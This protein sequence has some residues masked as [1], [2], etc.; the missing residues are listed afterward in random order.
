MALFEDKCK[1][2]VPRLMKDLNITREQAC[3]IFGNLGTETGGFKHLQ[4]LNPTVAGSRGGYGWMQ[5]TGPRRKAYEAWAK[6]NGLNIADDETNYK[7]LVYETLNVENK[8]LVQLRKTTT[9]EAAAETFCLLNLRPGVTHMASRKA[10]AARA[11]EATKALPGAGT[12]IIATTTAAT[13]ATIAFWQHPHFWPIAIGLTLLAGFLAYS[14]YR[15]YKQETI[16]QT[17]KLPNAK[18]PVQ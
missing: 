10:Y 14:A 16:K 15:S 12:V 5:W 11:Y 18:E 2:Y 1:K 6:K 9:V 17:E 3:G 13:T 8:S 4:E 7:Y